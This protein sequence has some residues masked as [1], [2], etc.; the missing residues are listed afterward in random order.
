M[1]LGS[2]G[3]S[4]PG[5]SS[6]NGCENDVPPFTKVVWVDLIRLSAG[7]TTARYDRGRLAPVVPCHHGAHSHRLHALF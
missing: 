6:T 1:D 4:P 5:G 7:G 3:G 2:G